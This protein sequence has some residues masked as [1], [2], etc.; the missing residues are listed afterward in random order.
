MLTRLNIRIRKVKTMPIDWSALRNDT[1]DEIIDPRQI[2][3]TLEGRRWDRLRPEQAEVLDCWFSNRDKRDLVIVQNTGAGKTLTG[4]LIALSSLKEGK[5]PAVFLVPH[6]YLVDQVLEEAKSA[7]IPVTEQLDDVNFR[8]SKSILV[9]TF[10]KLFNGKS[11]FGVRNSKPSKVELGTIVVD[12]AHA[13]VSTVQ[14]QFSVQIPQSSP[15]YRDVLCLFE[16]ELKDQ[17]QKTYEEIRSGDSSG[18]VAVP[19]SAVVGKV[20]QLMSTVQ[21]Y[22][23]DSENCRDLFF[24]WD[25]VAEML[26]YCSVTVTSQSV[27]IRPPCPDVRILLGFDNAKRRVY[28]TATIEDMGTMV[29][30]LGADPDSVKSPITP[31]Q[32]SDLG[33]RLI[34]APLLMN[35]QLG[36]ESVREMIGGYAHGDIGDEDS[37]INVV[38]LVPSD[39]VAEERWSRFADRTLHVDDMIDTI[40]Q[41]KQ[42]DHLGLVVLINKY[43]GIDLPGDACR[44]LV[45]D[46]VPTPLSPYERRSQEALYGS[47]AFKIRRIHQI[48]QGIGRGTRDIQDYCAVLLLDA[49]TALTLHDPQLRDAYSPATRAQID[50]SQKVAEQVSGEGVDALIELINEFL[51]RAKG[52]TDFSRQNLAS[53]TYES[54]YSVSPLAVARR[55]AF[56]KVRNGDVQGAVESLRMGIDSLTDDLEKGWYMEELAAY[57]HHI[58]VSKA[59]SI[60]KSAKQKN[61]TVLTPPTFVRRG[62]RNE[63]FADQV[64]VISE[65]LSESKDGVE[66]QLK[67][68][69]IFGDVIWGLGGVADRSEGGFQHIGHVLGFV[70]TRP[71]KEFAR[72]GGPDNLWRLSSDKY[73]VIELKTSI[74]REDK[75][76][77]KAE[78]AQLAHSIN[79]FVRNHDK[80]T[81]V[82]PLLVHPCAVTKADAHLPEGAR[83][84]TN[85][86]FDR[87]RD[88]V[89]AFVKEMVDHGGSP[90]DDDIAEGLRLHRLTANDIVQQY[91]ETPRSS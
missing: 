89:F 80:S 6:T 46:G 75:R 10:Q 28:L 43:H 44:L 87:L 42:G 79:W 91:T 61:S 65:F 49:D 18:V 62:R 16:S 34:L 33:D 12:D 35:P 67:V 88:S 64:Q 59:Q 23:K 19:F 50:S 70:S 41:M 58:D 7:R 72:D 77:I 21:N 17:N 9:A 25:L 26:K 31:K 39:R 81:T 36:F 56:D 55:A 90:S 22:A 68:Q 3:T 66:L 63:V 38:V 27:E 85:A 82:V 73:V 24:G 14:S 32:A 29:T 15:L 53:V 2:Y 48:E 8:A 13:A 52:W 47:Q 84:M 4:L 51:R 37:G 57:E 30:E 40:S 76:I 20:D 69:K 71:E 45:V 11:V 5:G 83:V 86:C 60:L 54:K 1:N 74:T 78:A